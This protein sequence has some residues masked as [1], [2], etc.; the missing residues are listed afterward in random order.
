MPQIYEGAQPPIFDGMG[1][2]IDKALSNIS[3]VIFPL[4]IL[5]LMTI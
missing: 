3:L 5:L 1:F 2:L 4:F